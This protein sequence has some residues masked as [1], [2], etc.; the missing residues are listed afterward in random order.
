MEQC[1]PTTQPVLFYDTKSGKT[2]FINEI[3]QHKGTFNGYV[4]I[5]AK[6]NSTIESTDPIDVQQSRGVFKNTIAKE[7][8]SESG[9]SRIPKMEDS[10]VKNGAKK[11]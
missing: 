9:T 5:F 2:I 1:F 6:D 4:G 10:Q 3:K 11:P 7:V 8:S